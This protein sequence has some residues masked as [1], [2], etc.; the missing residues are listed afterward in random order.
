MY[1]GVCE[2]CFLLWVWHAWGNCCSWLSC[3]AG[4]HC[5]FKISSLSSW[6]PCGITMTLMAF[7]A[8][9]NFLFSPHSS[10]QAFLLQHL[11]CPHFSFCPSGWCTIAF[12]FAHCLLCHCGPSCLN[13]RVYIGLGGREGRKQS[14]EAGVIVVW[15]GRSKTTRSHF[16]ACTVVVHALQP[17]ASSDGKVPIERL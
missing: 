10:K 8:L 2:A 5:C 9:S 7:G 16:S 17:W 6:L 11:Q 13:Q 1:W 3:R 4:A 12:P 15:K 14:R